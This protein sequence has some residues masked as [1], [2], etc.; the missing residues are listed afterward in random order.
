MNNSFVR[1]AVPALACLSLLLAGCSSISLWPFGGGKNEEQARAPSDAT[2]YRCAG[3]KYFYVRYLDS[4]G[5]AWIIFPEREFRLDKI[6]SAAGA[7]YSNGTATF[8]VNGSEATLTDGPAIAFTGC[9]AA[10]K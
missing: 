8:D 1:A 2:E 9:K 10:G 5:A 3:D 7:H 6:A 4:G